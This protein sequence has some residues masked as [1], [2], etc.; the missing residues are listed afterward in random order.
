MKE[1]K[2]AA[3]CVEEE[4]DVQQTPGDDDAKLNLPSKTMKQEEKQEGLNTAGLS[5]YE[6]DRLASIRRNQEELIRLGIADSKAEFSG[7]LG[8]NH[9][10]K[11]AKASK[12]V[13]KAKT[14]LVPTRRSTRQ[15][16]E[17][18][19]HYEV[20]GERAGKVTIAG[21]A[22][23]SLVADLRSA[24]EEKPR[25]PRLPEEDMRLE[26][27]GG[28]ESYGEGFMASLRTLSEAAE[29]EGAALDRDVLK[30]AERK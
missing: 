2:L 16:K 14:S 28:T 29:D 25:N 24:E 1:G 5:Q 15:A 27:T 17:T 30:Y 9:V 20:T 8:A 11:P 4:K 10:K 26:S 3:G 13:K 21:P 7:L 23:A 18:V 12:V 19:E 22:A 6:L